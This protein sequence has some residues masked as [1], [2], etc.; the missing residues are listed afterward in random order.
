MLIDFMSKL[1]RGYFRFSVLLL[2]IPLDACM[3]TLPVLSSVALGFGQSFLQAASENYSRD[4]AQQVDTLFVSL[5]DKGEM[6]KVGGEVGKEAPATETP[7]A[8]EV[9]LLVQ[10]R[11][12]DGRVHLLPL[13]D[14]ETLYDGGGSSLSVG[15]R[16]KVS[17]RSNQRCYVYILGLDASAYVSTIFPVPKSSLQNPVMADSHYLIPEKDIW[18]G[19]DA[20]KGVEQ[21]YFFASRTRRSDI[22]KLLVQ[23]AGTHR[24]VPSEYQPVTEAVLLPRRGYSR[25][26]G[27]GRREVMHTDEGQPVAYRPDLFVSIAGDKD[28]LVT[29]WFFHR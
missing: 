2:I 7:L 3:V 21:I 19:L 22:E 23:M 11:T 8:L 25:R 6:R 28:L 14:G 18:L 10:K 16:F 15:D 1:A 5:L 20:I 9:A 4:Y 26:S 17:V 27:A 29:R 24:D 13:N 12:V